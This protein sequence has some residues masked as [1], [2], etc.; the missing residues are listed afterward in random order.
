ME[1]IEIQIAGRTY[2]L[3]VPANEV[4]AV[5][6]AAT[7][8]NDNLK[9]FQAQ[10]GVDDPVDLLAMSALQW[11]TK[12][13]HMEAQVSDEKADVLSEDETRR[14]EDLLQRLKAAVGP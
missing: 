13:L 1:S 2:P 8:L 3:T 4:A 11:A 14:V 12:A 9:R 10:Y 6:E 7:Q 5:Q